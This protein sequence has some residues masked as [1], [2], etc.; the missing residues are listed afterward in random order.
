M[1]HNAV[2][3]R[4][5]MEAVSVNQFR[6]NLKECIDSVVDTHD[7]LKVTRRNAED[8]VVM[9][10]ED[11]ERH[12]ETIYILQNKYLMKQINK[13]RSAKSKSYK[14]SQEEIHAIIDI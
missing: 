7:I 5:I 2:Q 1:Y 4:V 12:Q 11:W 10:A 13:A 6:S 3:E 14:P 8:F 9:S